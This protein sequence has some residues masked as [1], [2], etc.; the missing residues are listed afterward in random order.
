M[1]VAWNVTIDF[2]LITC[3]MAISWGII[4]DEHMEIILDNPPLVRYA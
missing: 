4:L 2:D 1:M 3:L